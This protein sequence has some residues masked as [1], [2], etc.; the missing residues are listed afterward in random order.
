MNLEALANEAIHNWD[1]RYRR[2]EITLQ[3]AQFQIQRIKD[4]QGGQ[5]GV[6]NRAQFV[7]RPRCASPITQAHHVNQGMGGGD[8]IRHHK[9]VAECLG[10]QH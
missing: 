9:R 5:G 4:A 7:P 2:G 8:R 10:R 3:E 6:V 1:L